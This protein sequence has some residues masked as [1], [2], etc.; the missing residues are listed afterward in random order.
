MSFLLD[1][2]ISRK[3]ALGF[4]VVLALMIAVG[5]LAIF[6]IREI[7]ARLVDITEDRMPA[8]GALDNV[9]YLMARHGALMAR[10]AMAND[11]AQIREVE[12]AL[13]GA[14][15][16]LAGAV[17]TLRPFI[18]TSIE[19]EGFTA[20]QSAWG[21]LQETYA[22]VK[23][24]AQRGDSAAAERTFRD[25]VATF[26]MVTTGLQ[27]VVVYNEEATKKSTDESAATVAFAQAIIGIVGGLALILG[28]AAAIAMVRTVAAPVVAMTGAMRRLAEKDVAV[29]IPGNGRKDE[30][31]AMAG[32]VQVFK[33]NIIKADALEAA[34][35]QER[36]A[37][38]ARAAKIEALTRDFDESAR[39]VVRQ[40]GASAATMQKNSAAMSATAEETSRQ[41]TAVAAAAEQASTN[42]QTVATAAEELSSSISEISRQ[43]ADSSSISQKAVV[44]AEQTTTVVQD[45]A[46]A[47]GKIGS[48][49]NLIQQIA[50]QTNLLALNATIEAARAGDAGKGFA[51]VASE[52]KGLANQT[53][54]AT[55]EISTQ[56]EA[57]Q[58]A[59]SQSVE[60][61]ASISATI[62]R[63]NEISAAIAAAVE[64]Q[65]AATAEIARN[66][67][68][69]SAGTTE[70][71]S[72]ISG[73]TQAAADTGTV[74]NEVKSGADGV[75]TQA[76][77]LKQEVD[78]FLA[79]VRAA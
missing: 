30:I 55:E 4:G 38:E 43:V 1:L 29:E 34:A 17:D 53:A 26:D 28:V 11:A 41:A 70:V 13:A 52:V 19:R 60:A 6:E 27:R 37:R 67:Q 46:A 7:K 42:V 76:E 21:R 2:K 50:G 72:N 12:T 15:R 54:R 33:D 5:G 18:T 63:M 57:I 69:A 49:T 3:V 62:K 10:Y 66:V 79:S 22:G 32:A 45:L 65:G 40:L 14:E 39:R 31:G 25:S 8:V 23:S 59:S 51:V 68:Q 74:A 77:G 71:S 36:A 56:I 9:K 64:E 16:E 61:I 48:V 73:V 75:S 44:E 24:A 35:A 78:S 20:M 58:K 47:A